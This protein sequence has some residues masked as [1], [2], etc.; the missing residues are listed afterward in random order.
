MDGSQD[1]TVPQG[2]YIEQGEK[3]V[4]YQVKGELLRFRFL[5]REYVEARYL[6]PFER[7]ISF[8][9]W[10]TGQYDRIEDWEERIFTEEEMKPYLNEEKILQI[11]YGAGKQQEQDPDGVEYSSFLPAIAVTETGGLYA[12]G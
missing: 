10:K 9:N 6:V 4:R 1:Y 12:E 11:R 5:P 2:I 3:E 7:E 8:Y